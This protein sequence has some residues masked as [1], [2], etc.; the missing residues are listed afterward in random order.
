MSSRVTKNPA[1][2]N[3][4]GERALDYLAATSDYRLTFKRNDG[5]TNLQVFTDSSF[6]PSS[7]RSHGAA[8]VFYK[9]CALVWR[10]LR[11][12]MVTLS[13]AESELIEAVEG[14]LLGLS[15]K[16]LVEELTGQRPILEIR[17]DNQSALALTTGST[18]SWRARHLRLRTNWLKERVANGDIKMRFEPG[19]SQ[20]ADLGTKALPIKQISAIDCTLAIS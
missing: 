4:V 6:A 18:G 14:A 13:T 2:V 9:E 16:G 20:R 8:V 19:I 10:S 3:A 1:A 5:S 12:S 7:G 11:Q 17:V 15:T